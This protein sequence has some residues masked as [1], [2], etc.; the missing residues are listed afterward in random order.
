MLNLFVVWAA[1]GIWHGASWNY[2]IWGLYFWALLMIEKFFLLDK[3]K[4]AP[5]VIGHIYTM[6]LVL[7]SWAIF[8]LEDFGQLTA[9]LKVMRPK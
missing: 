3:L 6:A 7:V 9:Y 5:A 8:A 2:L 4:K 1:T